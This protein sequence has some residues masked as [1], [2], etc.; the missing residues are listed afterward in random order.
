ME[1]N[2]LFL[3]PTPI[4]NLEDITLRALNTLKM[5]DIILCEDTRET[6]KILKK[7][8]I[9]K[10]LLSCHEYNEDKMK[11]TVVEL[12]EKGNTLALVTDQGTPIISDPGYKVVEFLTQSGYN[13]VSLPG[14][15][16]F[17]PALTISALPPQPFL[18][19]GFLNAKE[20]KQ[21]Q[22]LEAVKQYPFTLIFYEA[23][24]RLNKTL[25]NM[26]EILGNRRIA[27]VREL[28]KK[29]E[30]VKRVTIKDFLDQNQEL[31]GE[32]VL[33]VEGNNDS[34]AYQN[35]S[36]KEHVELYL[37]DG[38]TKNEA[39]KKVAKERGIAKSIVYQEYHKD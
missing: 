6:G 27:I 9:K 17:V 34:K 4:G 25:Q 13:I 30:E 26:L 11:E 7:Y 16:A 33:V 29:Y 37:F 28:T 24:H 5:V 31:K 10:K 23:P 8:E 22:E 39:M 36:I 35:L 19:Y 38:L 2:T 12:L 3:V 21:K 15:T 1:K 32:I 14:P 18:F 20:G